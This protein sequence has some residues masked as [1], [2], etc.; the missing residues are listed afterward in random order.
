MFFRRVR[1]Q[2][3]GYPERIEGLKS[4]GF[5]V[6]PQTDGSVIVRRDGCRARLRRGQDERPV[7]DEAGRDWEGETAR[8][9]DAGYQKFWVAP[10]G[11]R[12]PALADEL[13]ALHAFEEDLREALGLTSLYNTSLGTVNAL[14][15]YD[16]LRD[17]QD[18]ASL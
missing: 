17:R 8:L 11:R 14:H 4:W 9:V 10:G 6:T 12:R 3:P 1:S 5:A 13:K 16:R 18:G 2:E 7:V 15:R